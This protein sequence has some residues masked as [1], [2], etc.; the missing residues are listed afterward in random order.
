MENTRDT[1]RTEAF[2]DGVFTVAV[3]LLVLDIKVPPGAD[4][5]RQLLQMLAR[6]WPSLLALF[7]SFVTILIVWRNH[8]WV[9]TLI[10]SVHSRL[11]YANGIVLLAVA[12][13]PFPTSLV[14]EYL[15]KPSANVAVALYCA[16]FL[17]LNIGF[18]LL[19][20]SASAD[21]RLLNSDV[22]P[23]TV[24]RIQRAYLAGFFVYA[25]SIVIALWLPYAGLAVCSLM[26]V[27]WARMNYTAGQGPSSMTVSTQTG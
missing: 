15:N 4:N 22:S 8:H 11:L 9:F 7:V 26:W 19:W 20:W 21:R 14:A 27:L 24:R 16:T 13:I 3:T 10:D 5:S 1:D 18:N 6:L 25:A 23:A 17:L 12:I 2:S